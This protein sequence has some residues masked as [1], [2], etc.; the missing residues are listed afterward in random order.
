MPA[1]HDDTTGLDS[2]MQAFE[3]MQDSSGMQYD[4]L[5]KQLSEL[6]QGNNFPM[7]TIHDGFIDEIA[8]GDVD[9][10]DILLIDAM[11]LFIILGLIG[12]LLYRIIRSRWPV[13][14]GKY[15]YR[16]YVILIGFTRITAR[17]AADM[18]AQ[19]RK[20]VVL[21]KGS[22]R[23]DAEILKKRGAIVMASEE[24]DMD[25]LTLA[26]I[27]NATTCIVC[28][29]SDSENLAI[30]DLLKEI[31]FHV[32][33]KTKLRI[34]LHLSNIRSV[35][36]MQDFLP[37]GNEQGS[38]EVV[39]FNEI[40]LAAQ[41]MFDLN[42]PFRYLQGETRPNK[43]EYICIIGHTSAT[44]LFLRELCVLHQHEGTQ[45]LRVF[46]VA[47][48]VKAAMEE[49]DFLFPFRENILQLIPV[50]LQ[51]SSFNDTLKWDAGFMDHISEIDAVYCFGDDDSEIFLLAQHFHQ[52]LWN[53]TAR[54]RRV[55]VTLCL[56]EQTR[57]NSMMSADQIHGKLTF[58][59]TEINF[60][61]VRMVS[62]TCTVKNL[63]EN[64]AMSN[65]LAMVVNYFEAIRSSFGEILKD[66]FRQNFTLPM[67][68]E[69]ESKVINF[70]PKTAEPLKE[71]EDAVL[72]VLLSKTTISE[73]QARLHLGIS[74]L[75][76]SLT[77]RRKQS[78]RY[79]VRH[80]DQKMFY[81]GKKVLI[82][83]LEETPDQKLKR[84]LPLEHKRWLAEK[85][86]TGFRYGNLPETE[87]PLGNLLMRTMKIND[88]MIPYEQLH[89][90]DKKKVED[91]YLVLPPLLAIKEVLERKE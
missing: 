53:K 31:K 52:L 9:K 71:L 64:S 45:C 69:I 48:N 82:N 23:A 11:F 15:F 70:R 29:G 12:Y 50:E 86:C 44:L 39:P 28:T 79:V 74:E 41:Q 34:L 49:I 19:G 14:R 30:V 7:D 27:R 21:V 59:A 6:Q 32:Y 8:D 3:A 37:P 43:T 77:E 24:I 91:M 76:E 80:I 61:F 4:S 72:G 33:Q 2:L 40:Q 18:R 90:D 13:I 20:V 38:A 17:I 1:P 51:N 55:P 88:C 60:H 57:L 75:W 66:R 22:A 84:L 83:G 89:A 78:H 36:I 67:L 62:D 10:Y 5:M 47:K 81:L 73:Y 65:Q 26:G 16:D 56:P 35:A 25:I 42:P 46:I 63:I 85:L 58:P 68:Q 54:V 87:K